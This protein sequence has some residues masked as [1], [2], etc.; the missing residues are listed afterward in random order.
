LFVDESGSTMAVLVLVALNSP[1]TDCQLADA[2]FVTICTLYTLPTS[3]AH[4]SAIVLP[5]F[6]F[7]G[8]FSLHFSSLRMP[9]AHLMLRGRCQ[10]QG[11]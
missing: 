11:E 5:N 6:A 10:W 7:L 3:D 1:V 8:F 2:M 9:M 4:A